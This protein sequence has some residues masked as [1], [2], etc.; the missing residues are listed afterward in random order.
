MKIVFLGTGAADWPYYKSECDRVEGER[1][2]VSML[3]DEHILID[4]SLHSFAYAKKIGVDV[5]KITDLLLS[6][7][8]DDHYSKENLLQ[9]QK[10]SASK[11]NIW[12]HTDAVEQLQ[13]S[14][15]E[16]S[17]FHIHNLDVEVPVKIGDYKV[18]PLEAN[19]IVEESNEIPLHY[20]I[21]N[22]GK[23]LF[24]GC[25]G[26]W[27]TSRTWEYMR[28]VVF[29][30]MILD[31]TVGDYMADYRIGTHNSIPMLRIIAASV[32]EGG[33]LKKDGV[34]LANHLALTLHGNQKETKALFEDF[35]VLVAYDGMQIEV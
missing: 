26:G 30:G 6:H 32:R 24:S 22:K 10:A 35:G 33:M 29:D 14:D 16:K 5:S 34:L 25:D 20:I 12:C 28:N 27:F 17:L 3:I 13:L 15:E 19:H 7:S 8:H 1:R 11:I 2:F 31:A 18:T 4:V 21:E 23:V 9:F